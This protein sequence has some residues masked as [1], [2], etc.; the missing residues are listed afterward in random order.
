MVKEK[1]FDIF[2]RTLTEDK[3]QDGGLKA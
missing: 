3:G 1:V 2:C